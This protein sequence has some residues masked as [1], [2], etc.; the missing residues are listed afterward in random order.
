MTSLPVDDGVDLLCLRMGDD[1]EVEVEEEEEEGNGDGLDK[2]KGHASS[3]GACS[4]CCTEGD[5]CD[6]DGAVYGI[7]QVLSWEEF[8][9]KRKGWS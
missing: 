6:C 4:I 3:H 8:K 5:D 7:R 1:E 9:K 2:V